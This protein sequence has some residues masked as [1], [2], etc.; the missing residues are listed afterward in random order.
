MEKVQVE[1]KSK[2]RISLKPKKYKKHPQGKKISSDLYKAL[3]ILAEQ[4]AIDF[5]LRENLTEPVASRM[6]H[7]YKESFKRYFKERDFLKLDVSSVDMFEKTFKEGITY[8]ATL[9][10]D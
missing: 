3:T 5:T 2:K 7:I 10:T 9:L 6:K 8:R 1:Y 4:F